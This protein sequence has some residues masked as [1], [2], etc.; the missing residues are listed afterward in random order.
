MIKTNDPDKI[1]KEHDY[2]LIIGNPTAANF[3][4]TF[5]WDRSMNTFLIKFS[6]SWSRAHKTFVDTSRLPKFITTAYERAFGEFGEFGELSDFQLLLNEDDAIT[7]AESLWHEAGG[8]Y[9]D[10]VPDHRYTSNKPS[11]GKMKSEYPMTTEEAFDLSPPSVDEINSNAE[12]EMQEYFLSSKK[13]FLPDD[14]LDDG[15]VEEVLKA[16]D[17]LVPGKS[18]PL[19]MQRMGR[20]TRR[21][22]RRPS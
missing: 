16:V 15:E 14:S 17:P 10:Q 8:H 18:D 2:Y 12:K 21:K 11:G 19:H 5:E 9:K 4:L 1:E 7:F 13:T 3:C 6:E 22:R 20:H